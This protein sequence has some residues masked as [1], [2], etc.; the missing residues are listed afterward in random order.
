MLLC[1]L[2]LAD[3]CA[4]SAVGSGVRVASGGK[5]SDQGQVTQQTAYLQHCADMRP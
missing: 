4:A 3:P 1:K 2:E 5:A